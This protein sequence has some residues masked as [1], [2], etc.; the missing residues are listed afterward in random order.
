MGGAEFVV[1]A[2]YDE[3]AEEGL[4]G[5]ELCEVVNDSFSSDSDT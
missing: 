4:D 1:E 2:E 5:V 3:D